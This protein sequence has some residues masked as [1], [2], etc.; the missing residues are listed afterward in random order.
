MR[1]NREV[2]ALFGWGS[3]YC[4]LAVY[5]RALTRKY[6]HF[7]MAKKKTTPPATEAAEVSTQPYYLQRAHIK[8]FRSIRDAKVEF[9]PGLNIIIGANGSG[10]TNFVQCVPSDLEKLT[11]NRGEHDFFLKGRAEV[12]IKTLPFNDSRSAEGIS[13][14]DSHNPSLMPLQLI[15]MGETISGNSIFWMLTKIRNEH[16]L[17]NDFAFIKIGYGIPAIYPLVRIPVDF[18]L[19]LRSVGWS[20]YGYELFSRNM[21]RSFGNLFL[22]IAN[23]LD[24]SLNKP[25]SEKVE[26]VMKGIQEGFLNNISRVLMKYTPIE[27][28]RLVPISSVYF[29]SYQQE[30]LVKGV[31]LEFKIHNDW[32]LF[33]AL[34]SGTQ[35]LFYIVSELIAPDMIQVNGKLYTDDSTDKIFFLEEPELGIHPDQLHRL[36]LFLR[37]QSE[38]HQLIITTHSPQVLDMLNEDELDRITICEL[39]EKKGTQFRKLTKAKIATAKKFMAKEGLYLSDYWLYSSLESNN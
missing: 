24:L 25:S 36:L 10:K 28:V 21:V 29:N 8:D 23:K 18:T 31:V 30:V 39:D 13:L 1:W 4:P 34:S 11:S 38:K 17:K 16:K 14:S 15:A 6:L 5:L 32:L 7:V 2:P 19:K 37:E 26:S 33:S 20:H 12:Q 22:N 9:K 27:G 35:R 3:R